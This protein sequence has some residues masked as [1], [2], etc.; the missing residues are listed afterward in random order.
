[1][2]LFDNASYGDAGMVQ[3]VRR[4]LLWPLIDWWLWH[5]SCVPHVLNL[6]FVGAAGVE[7]NTSQNSKCPWNISIHLW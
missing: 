1:M 7:Y 3:S 5:L 2:D 4:P 6:S